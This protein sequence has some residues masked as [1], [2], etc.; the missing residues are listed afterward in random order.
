MYL[1]DIINFIE[2]IAPL[3]HAASWDRSGLQVASSRKEISSLAIC[4][5]ATPQT[6]RAS[7]ALGADAVLSHHPIALKPD[8][9]N[10]LNGFHETLSLLLKNDVSLYAA[11]TSLDTNPNGPAGW[12]A[13]EFALANPQILSLEGEDDHFAERCYGYGVIG[14]LATPISL[15]QFHAMLGKHI[16][17][18]TSRICGPVPS[19]IKRIAYCPGAGATFAALAAQKG[20]DIFITGDIK[21]HD[22]LATDICLLDV[23]HHSLEEEMMRRM[24]LLLENSF[25]ELRINFISSQSPFSKISLQ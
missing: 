18:S 4:L 23:G 20:A 8:L 25:L 6:I 22:A 2:K 12:L 10:K 9:P 3:S 1:T 21:Y 17:L 16:D 19:K 5:D 7:I 14:D 15:Q 13:R 24:A 11:H